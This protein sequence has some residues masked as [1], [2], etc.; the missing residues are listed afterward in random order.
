MSEK[1]RFGAKSTSSKAKDFTVEKPSLSPLLCHRSFPLKL[2][3]L[4]MHTSSSDL[5]PVENSGVAPPLHLFAFHLKG[6]LSPQGSGMVMVGGVSP[7]Q[8]KIKPDDLDLKYGPHCH[9]GAF[10]GAQTQQPPVLQLA[11]HLSMELT[12]FLFNLPAK[13]SY[14]HLAI[15]AGGIYQWAL[16]T[17]ND[18]GKSIVKTGISNLGNHHIFRLSFGGVYLGILPG[19][20]DAVVLCNA[21][22]AIDQLFMWLTFRW[23]HRNEICAICAKN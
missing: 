1:R 4:S 15:S 16:Q 11:S 17:R 7:T 6:S 9:G 13:T 14:P 3:A 22:F 5:T 8:V 23:A 12:Q 18:P 2:P 21:F 20:Q 10:F 19:W